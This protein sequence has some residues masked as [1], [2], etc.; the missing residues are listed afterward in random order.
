MYPSK[1]RVALG[2]VHNVF[3]KLNLEVHA[4][5]FLLAFHLDSPSLVYDNT[6]L[7]HQASSELA[8]NPVVPVSR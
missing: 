5:V 4:A 3:E 1:P 8:Q 2:A 7:R 6:L